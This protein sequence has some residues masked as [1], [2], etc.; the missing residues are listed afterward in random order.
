MA[1]QTTQNV[2][3]SL[4]FKDA[5]AALEWLSRAF[6]AEEHVVYR[7]DT[8]GV[9]HA[10]ISLEGGIVMFG[11]GEANGGSVYVAVADVDSHY[12]RAKKAG[13][14]IT[15]DLEDTSYGS[16]EYSAR[17]LDGH[18]WHFGNYRPEARA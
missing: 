18:E 12:D 7:N 6:G 10:E 9:E 17:D 14:E 11:Q 2:F 13:A 4:R 5:N 3:P 8:G 15:R 1:D 16:R